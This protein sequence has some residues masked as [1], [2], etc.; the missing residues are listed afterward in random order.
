MRDWAFRQAGA[1]CYSWAALSSNDSKTR[2]GVTMNSR[3]APR[4]VPNSRSVAPQSDRSLFVHDGVQFRA[5]LL[6]TAIISP[7]R[8]ASR[9]RRSPSSGRGVRFRSRGPRARGTCT[10]LP[11]ASSFLCLLLF[12]VFRSA[13]FIR[14][15]AANRPPINTRPCHKGHSSSYHVPFVRRRYPQ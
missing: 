14:S 10:R 4:F 9:Q 5:P 3:T 12:L 13:F 2:C 7:P 8:C 11:P 1:G 6:T 15:H